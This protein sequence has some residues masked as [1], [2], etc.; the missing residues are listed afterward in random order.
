MKT[1]FQILLIVVIPM[2]SIISQDYFVRSIDHDYRNELGY[3]LV[4]YDDR[5]FMA[6]S[7]I[8]DNQYECSIIAEIDENGEF[9]WEREV[10]LLFNNRH[11]SSQ[12]AQ[13]V[14]T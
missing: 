6:V 5:I 8:C 1:L 10:Y 4:E 2:S 13:K 14:S 7:I 11:L 3:T 12:I 9:I